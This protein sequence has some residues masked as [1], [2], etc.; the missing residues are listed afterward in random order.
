MTALRYFPTYSQ[1]ENVVTNNTIQLFSFFYHRYPQK[2]QRVIDDILGDEEIISGLEFSLQERKEYSVPDARISQQSFSIFFEAKLSGQLDRSQMTRHFMSLE[3]G[4][5]GEGGIYLI[6]LTKSPI[7][8]V[9]K[10]ELEK[11]GKGYGVS[12]KA[13]TFEQLEGVFRESC[14][15]HDTEL[16][17]IVDD[18]QNFLQSNNLWSEK[19]DIMRVIACGTSIHENAKHRIY[20]CPSG[21]SS[22]VGAQFFGLYKEKCVH[23]V[24]VVEKVIVGKVSTANK[25]TQEFIG[26]YEY[27]GEEQTPLDATDCERIMGI[28][29][30]CEYY[31][32]L[33]KT[34]HRYYLFG[35]VE[36][37][38]FRKRTRGGVQ[39]TRLL[40]LSNWLDYEDPHKVYDASNVASELKICSFGNKGDDGKDSAAQD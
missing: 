28:I 12:F 2:A 22:M 4:P 5:E 26:H 31:P 24:C 9:E 11:E 32:N 37:T 35:S 3:Q 21:R 33:G 18:Y 8:A 23:H 38:K 14:A 7:S 30:A 25:D 1:K 17:G 15:P 19:G 29:A 40:N 34:E 6:G 36:E 20:F 13:I 16:I 39:G 27:G 10:E